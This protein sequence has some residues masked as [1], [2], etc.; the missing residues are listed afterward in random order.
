MGWCPKCKTAYETG[1]ASCPVCGAVLSDSP[2]QEASDAIE[3]V[4]LTTVTTNGEIAILTGLFHSAGIP[5]YALDRGA[6]GY[7]RITMGSSVYGQDIYVDRRHYKEARTLLTA[8]MNRRHVMVFEDDE[9]LEPEPEADP[10]AY[11][12]F[13]A[14]VAGFLLLFL[15]SIL[16]GCW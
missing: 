10:G 7:L 3:P 4:L 14:V 11:Q 2:P 13:V 15:Y 16:A 12:F 5:F 6:G 8:Y 9:N 1:A